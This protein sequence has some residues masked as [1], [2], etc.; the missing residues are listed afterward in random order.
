MKRLVLCVDRDNDFGFKS[1]VETPIVG[2]RA[3][4]KAANSLALVDP[5]D[6]DVN[7]LFAAIK[8]YDQL[9]EEGEKVSIATIC[10]DQKVGRISDEKIGKEVEEVL[11]RLKPDSII[12]VDDGAEDEAILPIISSRVK[13]DRRVRVTVKQSTNIESFYY[14]I[15][16]ILFEEK[17]RKRIMI[18][19]AAVCLLWSLSAF[20]GRPDLGLAGIVFVLGVSFLIWAYHLEEMVTNLGKDMREAVKTGNVSVYLYILSVI[21][22]IF[23]IV[24]GYTQSSGEPTP[25]KVVIQFIRGSI[26]VFLVGTWLSLFSKALDDYYKHNKTDWSLWPATFG[27]IS[28]YFMIL[29]SLTFFEYVRQIKGDD[30][31]VSILVHMLLAGIAAFV[32]IVSYGYLRERVISSKS[33]DEWRL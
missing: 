26:W 33:V 27:L 17:S 15:K 9:K 10:G 6:S 20:M 12:L 29:G 18:P 21:I 22:V 4:L 11:E 23:G 7:T 2:R 24:I 16:K 32:G 5:E 8:E 30:A 28:L 3:N 19:L 13:I 14:I 25:E 1:A 31:L